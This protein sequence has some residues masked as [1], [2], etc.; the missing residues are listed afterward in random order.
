MVEE[1]REELSK[2]QAEKERIE[3]E[4]R[5]IE[6]KKKTL[7]VSKKSQLDPCC[8]EGDDVRLFRFA[9]IYICM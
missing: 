4:E 8:K 3:S 7:A 5:V 2:K 9:S 1:K 6:E